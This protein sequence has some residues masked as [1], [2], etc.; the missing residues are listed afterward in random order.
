MGKPANTRGTQQ[1]SIRQVRIHAEEVVAAEIVLVRI[2]VQ[3][4]VAAEVLATSETASQP[5]R[6]R[7]GGV[8]NEANQDGAAERRCNIWLSNLGTAKSASSS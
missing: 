1:M 8:D 3:E 5:R 4:V 2:H 7:H 6:R